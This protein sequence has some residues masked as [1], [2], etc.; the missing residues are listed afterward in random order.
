VV[1]EVYD[2]QNAL[3]GKLRILN[4]K[5][6]YSRRDFDILAKRGM[7]VQEMKTKYLQEK[8]VALPPKGSVN[9]EMHYPQPP[10]G[11]ASFN[12]L[13]L[14]FDPVQLYKEIAEEM[15]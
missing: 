14:P 10:A 15:K 8:G 7:N 4:G 11:I 12:A 3:L 13:V 2:T 1:V 5:Q 9:L 6:I